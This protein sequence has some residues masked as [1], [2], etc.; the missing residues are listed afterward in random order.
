[1]IRGVAKTWGTRYPKSCAW[2]IRAHAAIGVWYRPRQ[3]FCQ[4]YDLKF[5]PFGSGV[6]IGV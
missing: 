5:T 6:G 4:R 3:C 2:R 1:M